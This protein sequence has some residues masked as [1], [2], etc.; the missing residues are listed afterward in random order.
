MS[1]GNEQ[2][3][4]TGHP[5]T[6]APSADSVWQNGRWES[7]R[8]PGYVVAARGEVNVPTAPQEGDSEPGAAA[9]P[10]RDAPRA[11]DDRQR[12]DAGPGEGDDSSSSGPLPPV[13]ISSSRLSDSSESS[14][15]PSNSE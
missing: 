7:T 2:P 15:T 11:G 10:R 12:D 14:G 1:R 5:N 6:P 3:R 9:R 8:Q 4:R 13:S